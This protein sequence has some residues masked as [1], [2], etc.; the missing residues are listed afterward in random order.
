[1]THA[2]LFVVKVLD[3]FHALEKN[4]LVIKALTVLSEDSFETH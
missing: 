3:W 2:V 4:N 1:M